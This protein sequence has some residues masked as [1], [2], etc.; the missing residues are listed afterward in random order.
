[1]NTTSQP[2]IIMAGGQSRRMGQ[3]KALIKLGDRRLVD[4]VF[5]RVT[6]QSS[7]IF[8]SGLNSF[9]LE[10]DNIQ[11]CEEGPNGPVAAL[12]AAYQYLKSET[13]LT[14]FF[15]I[16]V[17]A[18]N[19][20]LDFTQKIF[21]SGHSSI[22]AGPNRTHPTFA[23]WRI[24]D[25]ADIFRRWEKGQNLSLHKVSRIVG[26]K[27]VEWSD[28]NLFFNINTPNDAIEYLTLK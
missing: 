27:T 8:I 2:L 20:P 16:P 5:D 24:K 9:G 1:M 21:T 26:A 25:L 18:P 28:P 4:L 11:D 7:K 15:T 6:G 13:G 22:A 12:Y 14:G 19:L 10:I 17:D 23:W 3:D